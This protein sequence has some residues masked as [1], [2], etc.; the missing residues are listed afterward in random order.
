[1]GFEYHYQSKELFSLNTLLVLP[2][3]IFK[4]FHHSKSKYLFYLKWRSK[5]KK[6]VTLWKNLILTQEK[7]TA[8]RFKPWRSSLSD[9]IPL[10][11]HTIFFFISSTIKTSKVFNIFSNAGYLLKSKVIAALHHLL[12]LF[13]QGTQ[14]FSDVGPTFFESF[15][16]HLPNSS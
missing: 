15:K 1:M 8:S 3:E 4:T 11:I 5:W 14:V 10:S 2:L 9:H 16:F 13:F 6:Q 12:Y 7:S